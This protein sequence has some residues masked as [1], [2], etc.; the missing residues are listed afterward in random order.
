VNDEALLTERLRLR[1]WNEDDVALLT[2]L[3]CDPR[4]M[5]HIGVGETWTPEHAAEVSHEVVRHWT[6]YGFGWRVIEPRGGGTALGFVGLNYLGDGTDGLDPRELEIGWW[7]Q[8][9]AWGHGLAVEGARAVAGEAFGR[10]G[11]ASVVARLQPANTASARVAHR[12]GMVHELDATGRHGE[13]VA[14]YRLAAP[15]GP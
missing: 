3:S 8:A 11:A 9:D 13:P 1:R 2:R 6:V 4:V 10:L 7:L 14:V 12:L 5:R 15:A